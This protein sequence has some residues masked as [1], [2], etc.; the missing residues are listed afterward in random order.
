MDYDK[1]M[2]ILNDCSDVELSD[3]DDNVDIIAPKSP[4]KYM[5]P[6]ML[7]SDDEDGAEELLAKRT[8]RSL[9]EFNSMEK[10][11]FGFEPYRHYMES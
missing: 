11:K 8:K 10:T 6:L 2:H 3:A 5:K 7:D 9:K 1:I 4:I